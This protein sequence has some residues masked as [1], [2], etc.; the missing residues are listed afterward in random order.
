MH[1]YTILQLS[2]TLYSLEHHLN[3]RY[4]YDVST[5]TI[6]TEWWIYPCYRWYNAIPRLLMDRGGL[7]LH[8]NHWSSLLGDS[9]ALAAMAIMYRWQIRHEIL[10]RLFCD[11]QPL[12][13]QAITGSLYSEENVDDSTSL[14]Y[15]IVLD[16][17]DDIRCESSTAPSCRTLFFTR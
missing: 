10:Q 2:F 3:L 9:R 4:S 5:W 12:Q 14:D 1:R 6:V 16:I 15:Y 13:H 17:L 7:R 11:D 8:G